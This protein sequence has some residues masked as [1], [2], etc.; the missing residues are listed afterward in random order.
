MAVKAKGFSL[1]ELM[2]ATTLLSVVMFT[3]YYSYSL[4]TQSWKK[5]VNYYWSENRDGIA[6]ESLVTAIEASIPYLV[7]NKSIKANILFEGNAEEVVFVSAN[8]IFSRG[9]AVVRLYLNDS[10][11]GKQLIYSEFNLDNKP[12][13]EYPLSEFDWKEVVL[14]NQVEEFRLAYLGYTNYQKAL[15][16]YAAEELSGSQSMTMEWQSVYSV[17]RHRIMP[18]KVNFYINIAEKGA[19]DITIDLP[20]NTVRSLIRYYRDDI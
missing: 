7:N 9:S 1:V 20:Q 8:P 4:Y 5:R 17:E 18:E 13:I 11:F 12:I 10:E 2:I 14:F 16:A 6:L 15:D 19:S 3:G